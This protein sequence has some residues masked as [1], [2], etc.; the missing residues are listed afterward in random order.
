MITMYLTS[1]ESGSVNSVVK[2][3]FI[4]CITNTEPH[5]CIL[6]NTIWTK[7]WIFVIPRQFVKTKSQSRKITFIHQCVCLVIDT[8]STS[9]YMLTIVWHV[10]SFP[11]LFPGIYY[12]I[13]VVIHKLHM[14]CRLKSKSSKHLLSCKQM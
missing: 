5:T 12:A 4:S 11:T 1:R 2:C 13:T 9:W 7:T 3:R 6:A 8:F 14:F 10:Y